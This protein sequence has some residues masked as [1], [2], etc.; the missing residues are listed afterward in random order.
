MQAVASVRREA[1]FNAAHRLHN[2]AWTDEKN[3]EVFGKCNNP[4]FHGHNYR[5]I[6]EVKGV[7]DR[8]TGYVI[9]TKWLAELI[10]DYIE[11]RFDHR[12]LNEEV[13]EFKTLNPSAENIAAVIWGLLRPQIDTKYELIIE[14]Y[15]TER[16]SVRF[17]GDYR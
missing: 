15:E 14:L 4:H 5:L 2:P 12:N 11:D 16:N 6:V 17:A 9:D 13:D 10:K 1:H 7:I 8:E 3:R